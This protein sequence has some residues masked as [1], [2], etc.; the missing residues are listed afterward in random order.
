MWAVVCLSGCVSVHVLILAKKKKKK[1]T[2]VVGAFCFSKGESNVE[3]SVQGETLL[4]WQG[5]QPGGP[6]V[7]GLGV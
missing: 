7:S 3:S 6:A 5:G 1:Q 4:G 2:V